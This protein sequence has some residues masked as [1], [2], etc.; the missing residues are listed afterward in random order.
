MIP[1]FF[2]RMAIALCM[3]FSVT[4]GAVQAQSVSYTLAGAS[5]SGL[6]TLLGTGLDNAVKK[7]IPGST[8]T[9]QT[10][11]GGFANAAMV[12]QGRAHLGLIHDAE[13]KIASAGET[14]FR[15]PMSKLRVIGYMYDWAPMQ[16]I[17][18]K[19]FADEYGIESLADLAKQKAPVRVT[20][21]R[22]GNITGSIA[23]AILNEVGAN[24]ESVASWGGAIIAAGSSEQSSLF[25]NGRINMFTNGV[26]VGHSSIR[27]L[28]NAVDIKVLDVPLEVR[29]KISKQF[30]I[31]FFTIPAGS[32]K[33]QDKNIETLT[34]GAVLIVNEDMPEEEAYAL[35]NAIIENID[36][37]RAVHPSMKSLETELLVKETSMPFH[38]GALKAYKERGLIQ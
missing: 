2:N 19:K 35:T 27:E 6:W 7:S 31:G 18:A 20:V 16:F 30:G 26:F 34:L 36:S 1:E 12:Q 15:E 4:V 17:A 21:N 11:G 24:E 32:Y 5:P 3:C 28:E 10:T 33:N 25:Q 37:L 8:I 9:Y 23:S 13:L 29:E 22:A 14:P 38:K